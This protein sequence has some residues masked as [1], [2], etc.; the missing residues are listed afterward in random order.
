[1]KYLKI[2]LLCS[3][4]LA[5]SQADTN[6]IR[7]Y[8]DDI[9]LKSAI[10]TVFSK[11]TQEN[12]TNLDVKFIPNQQLSAGLSFYYKWFALTYSQSFLDLKNNKKYGANSQFNI[13]GSLYFP[14]HLLRLNYT[15]YKGFYLS[16]I[17]EINST[18]NESMSYPSFPNLNMRLIHFQYTHLFN[19]KKY[20][21]GAHLY[22]DRVMIK[23]AGSFMAGVGL[24]YHSFQNDSSFTINLDNINLNDFQEISSFKTIAPTFNFGY[25]YG[26]VINPKFSILASASLGLGYN[27]QNYI[28]ASNAE[29]QE[30][31]ISYQGESFLGLMYNQRNFFTTLVLNST[32]HTY[33]VSQSN[34]INSNQYILLNIGYRFQLKSNP[35]WIGNKIGL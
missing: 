34:F 35:K 31:K 7:S 9:I 27:F 17:A 1:M 28:L 18:W 12:K 2:L 8:Y 19:G 32:F 4:L 6:Y 30:H 13:G 22:G 15:H 21:L 33:S 11:F 16:N 29:I 14:K 24:K 3:P 26:F 10:E 23:N 5:F 25:G 20:T